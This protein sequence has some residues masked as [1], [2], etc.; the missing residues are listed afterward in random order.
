MDGK[1]EGGGAIGYCVGEEWKV[2]WSVDHLYYEK[3]QDLLIRSKFNPD[4]IKNVDS[5]NQI[6]ALIKII[7]TDEGSLTEVPKQWLT[8]KVE[9]RVKSVTDCSILKRLSETYVGASAPGNIFE[10]AFMQQPYSSIALNVYYDYNKKGTEWW[11]TNLEE[12][13]L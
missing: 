13:I 11:R 4:E 7:P 3:V 5:K 1:L 9:L 10:Q 12:L 6:A 2:L 8:K